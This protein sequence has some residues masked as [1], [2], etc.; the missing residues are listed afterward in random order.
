M[1]QDAADVLVITGAGGEAQVGAA[2]ARSLGVNAAVL[3]LETRAR[4]TDENA[5]FAAELVSGRV[6]VV[7]DDFHV[8]RCRWLFGRHFEH[9][10]VVSVQGQRWWRPRIRELAS[11]MKAL[12][13]PRR[14]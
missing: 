14:G 3:I 10:E 7:T 9:V 13:T 2:L 8:W 6:I 1:A 4:T 5:R 11:L 12:A